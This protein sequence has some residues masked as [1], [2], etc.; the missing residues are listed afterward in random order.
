MKKILIVLCFSFLFLS[1]QSIQKSD[2]CVIDETYSIDR[3]YSKVLNEKVFNFG[4]KSGKNALMVLGIDRYNESIKEDIYSINSEVLKTKFVNMINIET[5][6]SKDFNLD[7]SVPYKWKDKELTTA[8]SN[9]LVIVT[10]NKKDF[11]DYVIK[12][13]NANNVK[14]DYFFMDIHGTPV[15]IAVNN[16][17]NSTYRNEMIRKFSKA[18]EI[19]N[20]FS[21]NCLALALSCRILS[22]EV[23]T[24]FALFLKAITGISNFSASKNSTQLPKSTKEHMYRALGEFEKIPDMLSDSL[25][26]IYGY[27]KTYVKDVLE[28]NIAGYRRFTLTLTIPASIL[29]EEYDNNKANYYVVGRYNEDKAV[30]YKKNETNK[31]II[32]F[33]RLPWADMDFNNTK[34]VSSQ[35][36]CSFLE[37]LFE[38]HS[39]DKGIL[40]IE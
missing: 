27:Y 23:H 15:S 11:F 4:N 18:K 2:F 38:I 40:L 5:R 3:G 30:F 13:C 12:Y 9:F 20:C 35:E 26:K 37:L 16:G 39:G 28:E 33:D 22:D 10:D 25:I 7:N 34:T 19:A 36:F 6:Y 17:Q 32:N 24:P 8:N 14:F 21:K 29:S 1:C 31:I